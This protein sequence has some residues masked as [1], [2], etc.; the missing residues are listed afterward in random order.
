MEIFVK[1]GIFCLNI[2]F[3]IMKICPVQKKIT[4]IS[5]QMDTIPMDF[6]MVRDNIQKKDSSYK[7]IILA[8]MIPSDFFGKILYCFHM[9]KQMYH[10]ATSQVVLLDTYCISIS[11]LKQ[12]DSL[13]VIQMWHALGA[14]KKFGYSIL[15][16]AEGSSLKMAELMKMHHHYTYVLTS[17]EYTKPFFAEAFHVS[18]NKM[19]VFPLPKTDLLVNDDLKK[20]TIDRIYCQYPQLKNTHK[21]II[22]YAPTFRKNDESKLYNAIINLINAINFEK[23]E[24]ILKTH[25]LTDLHID[26]DRIIQDKKF[27]SLEFFHLADFIIT[28][29][30]A[31]LF[32][33][34]MLHKPIYF[35]AFDY[36]DYI[37]KRALYINYYQQMPGPVVKNPSELM[38]FIENQEVNYEKIEAF[39]ELMIVKCHKTYTDDFVDFLFTEIQNI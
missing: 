8:K 9:L 11:V 13:I 36:D 24:F 20:A 37:D 21:K 32:E 4:Y 30:S 17:S 12:R 10:I 2:L 19:K 3:S 35:Y 33:A 6:Q 38:D 15:G 34:S 1:I 27:T 29:Y 22:V 25:P 7:H 39:R 5:R 28:D 14:F 18:M 26:D 16:Q 31:V 23:F